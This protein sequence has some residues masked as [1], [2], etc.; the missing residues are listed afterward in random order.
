MTLADR[1]SDGSHDVIYQVVFLSAM[2]D[3]PPTVEVLARHAARLA[4]LDAHGKIALV[5]PFLDRS[6]GM[7]VLRTASADEASR[8]AEEDPMVRG[9]FQSY[10]VVAW[11]QGDTRNSYQPN[12]AAG[13]GR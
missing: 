1:D 3:R 9:G 6:G 4:D 2:P 13:E 8:I 10:R 7:I 11:A 12:L 5:G